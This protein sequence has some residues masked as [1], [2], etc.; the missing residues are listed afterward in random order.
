MSEHALAGSS[1]FWLC[2]VNYRLRMPRVLV[3]I[4]AGYDDVD[5]SLLAGQLAPEAQHLQICYYHC[6]SSFTS[7][8]RVGFGV[9]L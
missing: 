3:E 6:Y 7:T 1:G 5:I 4:L 8:K 2:N 9:P